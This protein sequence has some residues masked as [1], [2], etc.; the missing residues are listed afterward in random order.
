MKTCPNCHAQLDDSVMFC[1]S[2]GS[3][4]GAAAPE[5]E[6]WD[7]N[8]GYAYPPAVP[9]A[10][11]YDHT[12]E[13]DP[14]DIAQNKIYAMLIYL[15]GFIGIIIT[16]L[17]A[18]ESPFA[19]FH[20]RQGVKLSVASA[21]TVLAMTVLSFTFIVPIAAAIFLLVLEVVKIICFFNA[22]KGTAIEVPII[23]G[24]AMFN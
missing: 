15:T 10:P 23:R 6:R 21:A 1:A 7:P 8:P 19:M 12:T 16:L 11:N 13:F 18:K 2:C 17:A 9:A 3:P 14:A 4:V 5:P 20:I 22:S 24:I